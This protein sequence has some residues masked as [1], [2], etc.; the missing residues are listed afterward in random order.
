MLMHH[1][2]SRVGHRIVRVFDRTCILC[3]LSLT[4]A[5]VLSHRDVDALAMSESATRTTVA[6]A[7][8]APKPASMR[9]SVSPVIVSGIRSSQRQKDAVVRV[10]VISRRSIQKSGADNLAEL[11][12]EAPGLRINRTYAGMSIQ[13]QG[14]SPRHTLVL[15]DGFRTLGRLDGAI[16]LSRFDLAR[17]ERV[18]IVPG[19]S[20]ALFGSDALGGVINLITRRPRQGWNL[21]GTVQG[22]SVSSLD[23]TALASYGWRRWSAQVAGGFHSNGSWDLNPDDDTTSGSAQQSYDVGVRIGWRGDRDRVA[24]LYLDTQRVM[25]EGLEVRSTGAVFDRRSDTEIFG[26][27]LKFRHPLGGGVLQTA[28]R[29]GYMRHQFLYDQRGASAEDSYDDAREGL[30]TLST[31]WQRQLPRGHTLSVGIDA[32]AESLESSRVSVDRVERGRVA[33]FGQDDWHLAPTISVQGGARAIVDSGFGNAFTPNLGLRFVPAPGWNLRLGVGTG[34]RAPDA[35]ERF[36]R[37]ENTS[38]GYIVTG[39]SDLLPEK[40][41]S[42]QF[43]AIWRRR[44]RTGSSWQR[45]AAG[46][47]A[48]CTWVDDLISTRS[49]GVQGAQVV[50]AYANINRVRTLGTVTWVRWKPTSRIQTRLDWTWLNAID[51]SKDRL[52][53]GRSPHSVSAS[54]SVRVPRLRT[55][56]NLRVAAWQGRRRYQDLDGNGKDEKV[57]SPAYTMADLRLEQ[58]ISSKLTLHVGVDNV[59]N[60][61]DEPDLVLK[62]RLWMAGIRGQI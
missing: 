61:G 5:V 60:A 35:K 62:P 26:V 50:Y 21:Q 37:F 49:L 55:R 31:R 33:L 24:T 13:S 58:P 47:D 18:E 36:I 3:C 20:S 59:F 16:D 43:S 4:L 38:V 45:V 46:L 48:H 44:G 51:Q 22:G 27:G 14:L 17:I 19:A 40:S 25:K 1:L 39:A 42:L 56:L 28:G 34:F 15:T 57:Q 32:L 7:E 8:S 11:L 10:R 53:Q 30:A 52:L 9:L 29:V 41:T 54:V 23:A 12:A 6:Q 2:E